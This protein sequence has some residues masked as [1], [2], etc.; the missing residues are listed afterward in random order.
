[1]DQLSN[2]SP[3]VHSGSRRS[4]SFLSSSKDCEPDLS[5]RI[6][7]TQ[8]RSVQTGCSHRSTRQTRLLLQYP[9]SD[10]KQTKPFESS[11]RK[12]LAL[13]PTRR[14]FGAHVVLRERLIMVLARLLCLFPPT[15]FRYSSFFVSFCCSIPLH[16]VDSFFIVCHSLQTLSLFVLHCGRSSSRDSARGSSVRESTN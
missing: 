9:S 7:L 10:S 4:F 12:V 11:D 14:S 1:M 2:A 16:S 13:F 5:L 6:G 3:T 8:R 15:S